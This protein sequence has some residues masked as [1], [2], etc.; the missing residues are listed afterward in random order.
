MSQT[1]TQLVQSWDFIKMILSLCTHQ[2]SVQEIKIHSRYFKKKGIQ[3]M[4]LCAYKQWKVQGPEVRGPPVTFS[5]KITSLQ[6]QS[7]ASTTATKQPP[8]SEMGRRQVRV[9]MTI[10]VDAESGGLLLA[11]ATQTHL[12]QKESPIFQM[13]SSLQ[14]TLSTLCETLWQECVSLILITSSLSEVKQFS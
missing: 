12:G 11:V 1:G 5:F 4:K 3:F 2:S 6:Q 10:D 9:Q 8:Y 14:L 7:M 13:A